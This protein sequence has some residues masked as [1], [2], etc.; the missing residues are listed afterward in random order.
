LG[1][2]VLVQNSLGGSAT[3]SVRFGSLSLILIGLGV[4][5]VAT[6]FILIRRVDI[7]SI[8]QKPA[9]AAERMTLPYLLASHVFEHALDFIFIGLLAGGAYALAYRLALA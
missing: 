4:A 8:A 9:F 3:W 2:V 7:L 5:I 1:A 6:E